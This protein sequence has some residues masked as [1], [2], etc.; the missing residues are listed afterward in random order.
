MYIYVGQADAIGVTIRLEWNISDNQLTASDVIC[1]VLLLT[2]CY[3]R[4]GGVAG[5][6]ACR[7]AVFSV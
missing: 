3:I 2:S 1:A 5:E 7:R 6:Q 4:G